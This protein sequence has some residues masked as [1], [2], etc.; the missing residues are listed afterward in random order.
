MPILLYMPKHNSLLDKFNMDK[1]SFRQSF[2]QLTTILKYLG[3][4]PTNTINPVI[5]WVYTA[6]WFICFEIPIA[7]LPFANLFVKEDIGVLE[8]ASGIFYNLQVQIVPFKM[9]FLLFQHRKLKKAVDVLC[10]K[11]FSSYVQPEHADIIQEGVI[12][13]KKTFNYI[14]L[15]L[16]TVALITSSPL[17]NLREKPWLVEMWIPIDI[18][19]NCFNYFVVYLYTIIGK[20]VI[21]KKEYLEM[22]GN[23]YS[24][25]ILYID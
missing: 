5:Y 6:F 11:A 12:T 19:A 8:I 23:L 21:C 22:F 20:C 18:K 24:S 4:W 13:T 16:F 3:M 25:S 17:I 7:T 10:S 9:V 2:L 15:C 14:R 1:D